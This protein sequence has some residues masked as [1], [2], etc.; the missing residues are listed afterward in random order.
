MARAAV[1]GVRLA[2][3]RRE[4]RRPVS[5]ILVIGGRGFF[6]AAAVELLRRDG[7]APLA[8]LRRPR[9]CPRIAR[10]ILARSSTT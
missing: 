9:P 4:R 10:S 5:R 6:G 2:R 1:E 3:R 7:A 8:S